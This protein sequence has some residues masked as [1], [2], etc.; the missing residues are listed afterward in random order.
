MLLERSP[1]SGSRG[2]GTVSRSSRRKLKR[3]SRWSQLRITPI[4]IFLLFLHKNVVTKLILNCTLK[5]RSCTRYGFIDC[6]LTG[7]HNMVIFKVKYAISSRM[8]SITKCR[9]KNMS[10]CLHTASRKD[11]LD[12]ARLEIRL[13]ST[14]GQLILRIPEGVPVNLTFN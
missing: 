5:D 10:M 2:I 12:G 3:G 7:L 8:R 4:D 13:A 14:Q 1:S 6:D 9:C 11:L